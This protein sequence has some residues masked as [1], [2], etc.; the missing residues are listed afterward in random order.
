MIIYEK[1]TFWG[2]C[3]PGSGGMSDFSTYKVQHLT[4]CSKI[5]TIPAIHNNLLP[6]YKKIKKNN[7]R[8]TQFLEHAIPA[9]SNNPYNIYTFFIHSIFTVVGCKHDSE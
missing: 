3:T 4:E 1:N 5:L 7:M 2:T 8:R 6:P 9:L